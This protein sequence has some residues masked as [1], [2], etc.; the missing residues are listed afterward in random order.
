MTM[1]S[2]FLIRI[3]TERIAV[4]IGPSGKVKKE[5]EQL[6]S[7]S[8]EIDSNTGDVLIT[9]EEDLEDPIMMIKAR[10]MVKAIGR[11]FNPEKV[12]KFKDDFTFELINLKERVGDSPNIIKEVKGRIIGGNGKTRRYIENATGVF[13][14]VYGN[15]VGI[16]GS[17][18]RVDVARDAILRLI[19]GAKHGSVYNYINKNIERFKEDKQKMWIRTDDEDDI[20]KISDPDELERI[21][22][23]DE[24]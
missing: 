10:D 14:S 2:E 12:F 19:G 3:P 1:T 17:Y 22:F 8:M 16:I 18:E 15:T 6:T 24:E 4:L 21:V 5:L 23:D 9:M 11:G 20:A 13:V 7:S